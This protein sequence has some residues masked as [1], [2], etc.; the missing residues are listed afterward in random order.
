MTITFLFRPLLNLVSSL[1]C[2]ERES[3]FAF[4]IPFLYSLSNSIESDARDSLMFLIFSKE[5]ISQN[6]SMLFCI[7]DSQQMGA[8][9]RICTDRKVSA[10]ELKRV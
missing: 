7:V 9:R 8:L 5:Q 6:E 4:L 3:E 1:L 10:T 2:V